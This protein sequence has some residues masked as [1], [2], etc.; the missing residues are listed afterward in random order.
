MLLF[1][2]KIYGKG[3]GCAETGTPLL[4]K[5]NKCK[6]MLINS[7]IYATLNSITINY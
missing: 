2:N 3:I 5:E 7:L 4:V 1:A 6:S